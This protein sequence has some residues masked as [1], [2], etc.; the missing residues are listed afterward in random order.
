MG[1]AVRIRNL[2]T[3]TQLA[4]RIFSRRLSLSYVLVEQVPRERF[5]DRLF[6]VSNVAVTI[7][8]W[9]RDQQALRRMVLKLWGKDLSNAW[10]GSQAV[11]ERGSKGGERWQTI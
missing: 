11:Q 5:A 1:C 8:A 3:T 7:H 2:V 10:T 6:G 9:F 4:F